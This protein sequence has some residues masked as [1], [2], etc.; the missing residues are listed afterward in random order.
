MASLPGKPAARPYQLDPQLQRAGVYWLCRTPALFDVGRH[1]DAARLGDPAAKLALE[2]AQGLAAM[3]GQPPGSLAAVRQ[4]L[5]EQVHQGKTTDQEVQAATDLLDDADDD[6]ARGALPSVADVRTVLVRLVKRELEHDALVEG[7]KVYLNRG[8][9]T[10]V[11]GKLRDAQAL[12]GK[13]SGLEV[14]KISTVAR[15]RVRWLWYGRIPRGKLTVLEGDPGLGK[16]TLALD[17]AA[18]LTRGL[19]MPGEHPDEHSEPADVVVVSYEDAPA[20][21]IRPR[22][23]AAGADL[24]RVNVIDVLG[25]VT[26]AFPD[27]TVAV[28]R[29]VVANRA[30]LLIIDPLSAALSE[31]V[32]WHRDGAGGGVRRALAPLAGLAQRT[33]AAILAVRHLRKPSENG[34][35]AIYRGGGSIG[36]GGAAR[37][38]LLVGKDQ[39]D[40]DRRIIVPVKPNV[41]RMAPA[42]AFRLEDSDGAGRIEWEGEVPGVTADDLVAPARRVRDATLRGAEDFLLN[43]LANGPVPSDEM[44]A[45]AR[46]AGFSTRTTQRARALLGVQ[47]TKAPG[48]A[49]VLALPSTGSGKPK[50]PPEGGTP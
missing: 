4:W 19:P 48:G 27:D 6:H 11:I 2:A 22:L 17:V 21:T 15:E 10:A 39:Q 43:A 18:R 35:G 30:G 26:V 3:S 36:I 41:A 9:L 46:A 49:W 5:L 8:D 38:V 31:K 45:A 33:G 37:S 24:D 20:D 44:E 42:L 7:G 34:A 1:L 13:A 29:V 47:A 14:L 50:T 28:E 40:P 32:D 16:S 12:D 23:E 25:G